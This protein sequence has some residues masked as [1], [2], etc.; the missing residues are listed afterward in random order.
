MRYCAQ[1]IVLTITTKNLLKAE[2]AGYHVLLS[3]WTLGPRSNLYKNN[4]GA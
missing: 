1:F 2:A 3:D 4:N